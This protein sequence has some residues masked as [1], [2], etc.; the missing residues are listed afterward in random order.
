MSKETNFQHRIQLSRAQRYIRQ[1]LGSSIK[2][3]A[4]AVE[5]GVSPYHF[6]RVFSACTGET[7]FEFIRRQRILESL[8]KLR[9]VSFSITE[10]ALSLGFESSSSFNKA[11][12]KSTNLS[13]TEFRNLGKAGS[14]EIEYSLFATKQIKETVMTLNLSKTPEII[15]RKKMEVF[16]KTSVGGDFREIAP[17]VWTE[18]TSILGLSKQDLSKSEFFGIGKVEQGKGTEI[19]NTYSAAISNPEGA[20]LKFDCL[21]KLSL[22]EGK[23]AKFLLKGSYDGV[24]LSFE[25]AFKILS[26]G[27]YELDDRPCLEN[28]LNDPTVTPEAELLTEI[29]IPIR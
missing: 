22:P 18:F 1:N 24:W 9:K 25:Q 26:E 10:I 2:L 14:R 20:N 3:D 19:I 7:P 21:E 11:F 6:I 27:P 16:V 8:K 29:L 13:P 12:K 5:S 23:Y 4:L 17:A 28:Y 15:L